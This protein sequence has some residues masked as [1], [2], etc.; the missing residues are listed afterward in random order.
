MA[1]FEREQP[2]VR[3]GGAGKVV[4]QDEVAKLKAEVARLKLE[5]LNRD[6]ESE[7]GSQAGSLAGSQ[8]GPPA[9]A[10]RNSEAEVFARAWAW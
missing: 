1:R 7:A 2:D 8:A 10:L 4:D 9:E 6:L 5:A 3:T